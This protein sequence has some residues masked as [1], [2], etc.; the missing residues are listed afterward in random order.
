VILK[1]W[2]NFYLFG[3]IIWMKI[4]LDSGA[5]FCADLLPLLLLFLI[6]SKGKRIGAVVF[7]SAGN[8][9]L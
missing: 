2:L 8:M 7:V 4:D 1:N 6:Y 9:G 5:T 3:F